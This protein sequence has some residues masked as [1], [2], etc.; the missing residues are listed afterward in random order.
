MNHRL[1]V[2]FGACVMTTLVADGVRSDSLVSLPPAALIPALFENTDIGTHETTKPILLTYDVE[3][4]VVKV[5]FGPNDGASKPAKGVIDSEGHFTLTDEGFAYM[6][7][8][9]DSQGAKAAVRPQLYIRSKRVS[10]SGEGSAWAVQSLPLEDRVLF[11]DGTAVECKCRGEDH[12]GAHRIRL[13]AN[14]KRTYSSVGNH[15]S[16][17]DTNPFTAEQSYIGNPVGSFAYYVDSFRTWSKM[18]KMLP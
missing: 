3:G 14:N 10:A 5:L 9:D 12:L 13:H 6:W 1:Q 15:D 11:V 7:I 17:S 4:W 16:T 18:P 2:L 8:T